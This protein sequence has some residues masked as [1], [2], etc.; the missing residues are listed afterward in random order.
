MTGCIV[1]SGTTEGRILSD[2]LSAH[3]IK[4]IVCVAGTYGE[5]MM[6]DDPARTVHVGRMDE[7]QMKEFFSSNKITEEGIIIDATHPYASE[8]TANIKSACEELNLKY[9]RVVRS[10]DESAAEGFPKYANAADCAKELNKT[11]S[12]ILLT[13]GSKELGTYAEN[14][15]KEVL[16]RTYVRVLPSIESLELCEK[17]GIEKSHIIA[18]HGPF[19]AEMNE[20]LIRQYS[21]KHLVTK[22]SGASGGFEEKIL[23]ARNEGITAHIIERPSKEEGVSVEAALS[24]MLADMDPK[25]NITIAGLGMGSEGNLTLDAHMAIKDSDVIFGAERL[26]AGFD[27][28]K[29]PLYLAKDII[30]VLE[31]EKPLRPVILYSGDVS[32]YSGT[33][34][35]IAALKDWREDINIRVLPGI[36]SISYLASKI[37]TSYDDA[38]LFS[39][40]GHDSDEDLAKLID[41][42]KY[43]SKVFTLLS[44]AKDIHKIAEAMIASGITGSIT[45]GNNLSYDDESVITMSFDEALAYDNAGIT[46]AFISNPAPA[47]KPL[48]NVIKDSD[49]IRTDVPMTKECIRHESI[50]RLELC[51]GDVLY[52]VGGGT[53]SVSIEAAS[54]S[55]D[56][57]VY[58]F[59]KKPEAVKLIKENIKKAGLYN[60]EVIEGNAPDT[61]EGITS[62]DKVFIGGSEG[63]LSEIIAKLSERKKGIRYVVNAVSLETIDEVKKVMKDFEAADEEIIQISVSGVRKAGEHHLL[64]AQNPVWIFSFTI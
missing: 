49:M 8:V 18:M 12:N 7:G 50:I 52:D 9:V 56:L 36:S 26:I 25:M 1:F 16:D 48:I 22:E 15:S 6:E 45:A 51:E 4:H 42:I 37:G 5:D 19:S 30:P 17:A 63:R 2:A 60:I 29:Y 3:G 35:M 13:T 11:D 14:V 55:R 44:G 41:L 40:H 57:K 47:R 39:L 24:M 61:F 31:S 21:I 64:S 54:L 27:K 34:K 23:A 32:F 38:K 43:N 33:R 62:P 59:E 53:G 46:T 10:G 28:K 58:T 20:A